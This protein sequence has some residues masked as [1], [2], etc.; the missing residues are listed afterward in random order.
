LLVV[1]EV[2][3]QIA[4]FIDE[5]VV[6]AT[7]FDIHCTLIDLEYESWQVREAIVSLCREV[8]PPG[9]PYFSTDEKEQKFLV[10]L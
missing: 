7:H 3:A 8:D 10:A 6:A 4:I 5:E 2:D 1:H 9:G